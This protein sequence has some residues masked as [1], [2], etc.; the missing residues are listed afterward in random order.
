VYA[1]ID[2]LAATGH[3]GDWR[4]M[5]V[6]L[7]LGV[8]ASL[9]LFACGS[10]EAPRTPA[11]TEAPPAAGSTEPCNAV[12][13]QGEPVD[14]VGSAGA[15]PKATGG[16]IEDGTYVLTAITLYSPNSKEDGAKLAA[17]GKTTMEIK[18]TS[19]QLVRTSADGVEQRST[20]ARVN[21]GANTTATTTCVSPPKRADAPTTAQYSAS[22]MSL[23][24]ISAGPAGTSVAAYRKVR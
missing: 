5:R 8:I 16:A 23:L 22:G 1:L 13:Q 17:L 11:A 2:A 24:L 12:V 7:S 19:S 9:T 3:P 6:L 20:V 15:P 14:L 4:V 18:G 10:P 21:D